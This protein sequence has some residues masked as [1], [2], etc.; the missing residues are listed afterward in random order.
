MCCFGLSDLQF[1]VQL[2]MNS[3]D[4]ADAVQCTVTVLDSQ[5]HPT[6]VD[7]TTFA[8][9]TIPPGEVNTALPIHFG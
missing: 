3:T 1:V 7:I 8:L 9:K 2:V 5:L 6:D 4:E